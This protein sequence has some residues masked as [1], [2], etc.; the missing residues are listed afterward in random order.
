MIKIISYFL[1]LEARR[2]S[3]KFS[4]PMI[5]KKSFYIIYMSGFITVLLS[6]IL[7][8]NF[9]FKTLVDNNISI[10]QCSLLVQSIYILILLYLSFNNINC[11]YNKVYKGK[12]S[13]FIMQSGNYSKRFI[14]SKYIAS[15]FL[16]YISLSS[17]IFISVNISL[18]LILEDKHF[19]KYL[20]ESFLQYIVV[21]ALPII[22]RFILI[23]Y[24]YI[25]ER[26]FSF[27]VRLFAKISVTFGISFILSYMVVN[28]NNMNQV[29]VLEYIEHNSTVLP[30]AEIIYIFVVIVSAMLL[31]V[32]KGLYIIDRLH[33]KKINMT[34]NIFMRKFIGY[35]DKFIYY[36]M[37]ILNRENS[38]FQI[39]IESIS[40]F[41][42]MLL[43]ILFNMDNIL[44][45]KTLC[46]ILFFNL[47]FASELSEAIV[48]RVL[49]IEND[50]FLV[51]HL[52]NTGSMEKFLNT[53]I[54]VH[55][56]I[57]AVMNIILMIP[58]LLFGG[59]AYGIGIAV[60]ITL[61]LIYS[62]STVMSNTLRPNF[63]CL[64][65]EELE[66]TLANDILGFAL[67]MINIFIYYICCISLFALAFTGKIGPMAFWGI[68]F[69]IMLMHAGTLFV[70]YRGMLLRRLWE[71]W[72]GV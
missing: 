48:K 57:F 16:Q 69:G 46:S 33:E 20:L 19:A 28:W 29:N 31:M 22:L 51:R 27:Y 70:F 41:T 72:E 6:L 5:T 35:K 24:I 56:I 54:K 66:G 64:K 8:F 2:I 25:F 47:I 61:S 21:I 40:T 13:S 14:V 1:L 26:K 63:G 58:G 34:N 60:A 15:A 23:N 3:V 67:K 53:K 11:A 18:F 36:Q 4:I 55:F 44:L 50:K 17:I 37:L 45:D 12:D 52:I 39:L 71:N 38:T 65:N 7:L 10:D 9:I 68:L 62:F 32:L 42:F 30:T 59:I 49:I 43:G